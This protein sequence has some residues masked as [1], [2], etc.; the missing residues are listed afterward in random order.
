MH[1]GFE[2]AGD[3]GGHARV[4]LSLL[5][6]QKRQVLAILDDNP[7]LHGNTIGLDTIPITGAVDSITQYST[8]QVELV[9]AIGSTHLP[10]DRQD[11]YIKLSTMGY[12]FATLIHP[13]AVIAPGATIHSGAQIMAGAIIQSDSQ[14][15]S[16]CL[17]NTRASIDHDTTIGKHT[18][19]APG[20]TICGSVSIGHTCHI[21]AGATIIHDLTIGHRVIIGAGA[22]VLFDVPEKLILVGT[23][24]KPLR[25]CL[26]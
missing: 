6:L 2:P 15:H 3:V 24:A 9:N 22:T 10:T 13:S 7:S 5:R 20:V 11:I 14:L 26:D 19:I 18:H 8:D 1:P 16:N 12:H 4:L 25:D 21:G 17:I 23:P